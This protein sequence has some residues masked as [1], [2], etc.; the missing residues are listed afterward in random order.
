MVGQ[1]VATSGVETNAGVL[2]TNFSTSGVGNG[3]VGETNSP[4]SAAAGVLG[5]STQSSGTAH[6]D[7][8]VTSSPE[9]N[10][11]SSPN[12]VKFEGAIHRDIG[13][14]VWLS[15]FQSI[16]TRSETRVDYDIEIADD[17]SEWDTSNH[18]FVCA[19]AGSY[20]ADAD[21][22]W[23]DPLS[24]DSAGSNFVSLVVEV[25]GSPEAYTQNFIAVDSQPSHEV[26]TTLRDLSAGDEI[27]VTIYQNTG[28]S[29]D[30]VNHGFRT[31]LNST[32]SAPDRGLPFGPFL[33][34]SPPVNMSL[35]P[36][37]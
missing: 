23:A 11:L 2:G 18:K 19:T 16:P 29:R 22:R 34:I 37:D 4:N 3:V 20:H 8:G 14:T 28:Q 32:I 26:T 33:D 15:S 21:A 13:A 5:R 35:S 36:P 31:N 17:R 25:N 12:D 30:L 1:G 9:G 10:G 27:T 24:G 7:R 6:G